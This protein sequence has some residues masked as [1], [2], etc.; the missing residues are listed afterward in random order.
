MTDPEAADN[1]QLLQKRNRKTLQ[2]DDVVG[3]YNPITNMTPEG[4]AYFMPRILELAQEVRTESSWGDCYLFWFAIQFDPEFGWQ[5]F[6][7]FKPQHIRLVHKILNATMTHCIQYLKE[8]C[9]EEDLLKIV[10]AWE[11]RC[12]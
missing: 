5:K 6:T 4:M 8:Q 7:L 3:S 11:M 1:N 12:A 9:I 10:T 2:L